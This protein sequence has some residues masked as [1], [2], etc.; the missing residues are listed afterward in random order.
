MSVFP[1]AVW[2][3]VV[4]WCVLCSGGMTSPLWAEPA[5]IWLTSPKPQTAQP[6]DVLGTREIVAPAAFAQATPVADAGRQPYSLTAPPPTGLL[7]NFSVFLGLDG[8]KQP[9]DFGVNAQFGGRASFNWGMP[10]WAPW[11]LGVQVG[12]ALDATADAVQVTEP[13]IGSAGRTQSFT[14]VGVF[15]R[16]RFGAN[17]GVVYDFLA[18]EYYSTSFLGQWRINVSLDVTPRSTFGAW[19]A[20]NGF[21]DGANFGNTQVELRPI[22]QWPTSVF[23]TLW[24]GMANQ[25]GQVNAVL[26][27]R[28]RLRDTFVFGAELLVPLTDRLAIF[29][30]GNFITPV[31]SGT[32]DAYLGFVF[33]PRGGVRRAYSGTYAP[34]QTVAAPTNFALDLRRP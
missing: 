5:P 22:T 20:L 28:P 32:V 10:L 26:G 16:T 18:Q 11:G 4:L 27:D 8:A 2:L 1:R 21:G 15:Q 13:L 19:S 3:F 14:T 31:A 9:Q 33:Y 25:H 6:I 30:Q 24:C 17:W 34:L 23:T 12:T 7:D 29:G